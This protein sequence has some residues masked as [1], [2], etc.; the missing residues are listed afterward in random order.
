MQVLYPT[1]VTIFIK[2][3]TKKR[4]IKL[5][6][7]IDIGP[8]ARNEISILMMRNQGSAGG[9]GE[10]IP[11]NRQIDRILGFHITIELVTSILKC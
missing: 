7:D 8:H 4:K 6:S 5:K 3:L 11:G 1:L 9:R 2:D 10:K